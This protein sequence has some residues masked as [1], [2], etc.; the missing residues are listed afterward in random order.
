MRRPWP[1]GGLLRQ[2]QL[3]KYSKKNGS[4]NK[5]VIQEYTDFLVYTLGCGGS[6]RKNSGIVAG[7]PLGCLIT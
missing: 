3:N 7:S 4:Y 5:N 6:L 2:K 1:T